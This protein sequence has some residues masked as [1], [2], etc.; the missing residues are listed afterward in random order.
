MGKIFFTSDTH[1]FHENVIRLDSRTFANMDEM[2]DSML[3]KWNS[4]VSDQDTVYILGDYTWKLDDPQ[5]DYLKQ[6]KGHKRIIQGNHCPR[7][8]GRKYKDLFVSIK[9]YDEIKVP[10]DFGEVK[11]CVLSHYFIPLYNGHYHGNIMLYGHSHTT[12]ESVVEENYKSW[13]NAHGYPCLSYNVGC[14][15]WNYEPVTLEEIL[16]EE[17]LQ[18]PLALDDGMDSDKGRIYEYE[19]E[20]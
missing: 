16:K 7:N 3:Q 20:K 12:E 2:L 10:L 19:M 11:K 18:I 17:S 4:K 13:L 6:L 1:F 14:M 15:R 5:I 9:D 8:P